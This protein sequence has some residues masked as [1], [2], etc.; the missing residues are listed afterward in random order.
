MQSFNSIVAGILFA[1]YAI[2]K[3]PEG[4]WWFSSSPWGRFSET[5]GVFPE[6]TFLL[7]QLLGL[8]SYLPAHASFLTLRQPCWQPR[9]FVWAISPG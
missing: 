8:A 7:E 2:Q 1:R 9:R 5:V 6:I 4:F 3:S